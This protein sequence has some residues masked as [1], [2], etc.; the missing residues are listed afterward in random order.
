MW[1][2]L[3]RPSCEVVKVS[4]GHLVRWKVQIAGMQHMISWQRIP[5]LPHHS[6]TVGRRIIWLLRQFPSESYSNIAILSIVVKK[7]ASSCFVSR[8]LLERLT[9][10]SIQW[11]SSKLCCT[12]S[13]ES[14]GRTRLP[15]CRKD[16]A[17]F[18]SLLVKLFSRYL[19]APRALHANFP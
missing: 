1:N 14:N 9:E 13:S 6:H 10:G 12:W 8:W 3:H 18:K 17:K 19:K 4:T 11:P 16:M 7:K 5:E 2:I 15:V